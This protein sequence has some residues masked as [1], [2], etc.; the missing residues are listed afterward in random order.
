MKY[1]ITAKW[2]EGN[3]ALQ[4]PCPTDLK[5]DIKHPFDGLV[6]GFSFINDR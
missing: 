4:D 3:D 5:L 1:S 6:Y 2:V